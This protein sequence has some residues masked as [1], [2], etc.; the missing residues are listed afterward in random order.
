MFKR[1]ETK[2]KTN[3]IKLAKAKSKSCSELTENGDLCKNF[4]WANHPCCYAHHRQYENRSR[5]NKFEDENNF[6]ISKKSKL[7]T[8]QF[9]AKEKKE[10]K[11]EEEEEEEKEEKKEEGKKEKEKEEEEEE[12]ESKEEKKNYIKEGTNWID[13]QKQKQQKSFQE[14]DEIQYFQ[15]E[16]RKLRLKVS[17]YPVFPVCTGRRFYVV[18]WL[19]HVAHQ[20]RYTGIASNKNYKTNMGIELDDEN[21]GYLTYK[22]GENNVV[23]S[24]VNNP[25]VLH[26]V[27]SLVKSSKTI[28]QIIIP[29]SLGAN[30]ND[31]LHA[32]MLLVNLKTYTI[33]RYNPWGVEEENE[34]DEMNFA[35][36]KIV[37]NIVATLPIPDRAALTSKVKKLR[38]LHS[39]NVLNPKTV[40]NPKNGSNAHTRKTTSNRSLLSSSSS[41]LST[42][43][44]VNRVYREKKW[45]M[46]S[47][48]D[49]CPY[50]GPQGF[51]KEK[52][53]LNEY[54]CE[55]EDSGIGFCTLYSL[56]YGHLRI[57][58][59]NVPSLQINNLLTSGVLGLPK[60][61]KSYQD[62][63]LDFVISFWMMVCVETTMFTLHN[64]EHVLR[65][66][67]QRRKTSPT[68]FA[69]CEQTFDELWLSE[70]KNPI[71]SVLWPEELQ[72]L[73]AVKFV[74]PQFLLQATDELI[75]TKLPDWIAFLNLHLL[76]W[77]RILRYDLVKRLHNEGVWKK[78]EW[79]TKTVKNDFESWVYRNAISDLPEMKNLVMAWPSVIADSR[80]ESTFYSK[81]E[82]LPFFSWAITPTN[83]IRWDLATQ[84]PPLKKTARTTINTYNN[85]YF[86]KT[87][88]EDLHS[89]GEINKKIGD[90]C[91]TRLRIIL[92]ARGC[93]K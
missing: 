53:R 21:D 42:V 33:E 23:I 11:E 85:E 10:E 68:I 38:A 8:T 58:G 76:P 89:A 54:D 81:L 37:A 72:K 40:L 27:K 20:S 93:R 83:R 2:E 9:V 3:F 13:E 52:T 17:T 56:L 49:T 36:T 80:W 57:L 78:N 7:E 55:E 71:F 1:A 62:Q 65:M 19:S 39:K 32:N 43:N 29:I 24:G 79:E 84:L 90:W 46:L 61:E 50:V 26:Q 28:Q 34:T 75:K 47:W 91:L 77:I 59:P 87:K 64:I 18:P 15:D 45:R 86:F 60:E 31:D 48:L 67:N 14:L 73:I 82:N 41:S 74:K 70:S 30:K 16:F 51:A 66:Q 88:K 25:R 22:N 35:D 12:E 4:V 92:P 5:K 6:L 44:K 69:I 63:L